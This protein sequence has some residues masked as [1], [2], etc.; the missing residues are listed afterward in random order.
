MLRSRLPGFTLVTLALVSL[1]FASGCGSSDKSTAP[2]D[3][4]AAEAAAQLGDQA[5]AAGDV[6]AANTHYKEALA[7]DPTNSHANLGAAVTEMGLLE[8]DAEVT[9]VADRLYPLLPRPARASLP[10]GIGRPRSALA[11][12][13]GLVGG[14]DYGPRATGLAM[15]NLL[16]RATEDPPL[17]SEVQSVLRT[18]VMPRLQYAEDRLGVLE[19]NANFSMLL[20][21][22][23]T[24]GPDT[25]EVDL[26]EVRVL[27]AVINELQGWLGMVVAYNFDFPMPS[28]LVPPDSILANGTSFGKLNTG[29][30]QLL[31]AARLDFLKAHTIFAA[32]AD[33]IA[34]ETDNQDDDLIP[35]AALQEQ[36][37][38]QF[39]SDFDDVNN[40]LQNTI[41]INVDDYQGGQVGIQLNIGSFFTNAIADW[42]TKLPA[43]TFD[44]T[45]GQPLITNPVTFP[46]PTFNG[47][48]PGMTNATWQSI[49]GPVDRPALATRAPIR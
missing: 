45:T 30:T 48:F 19:Q 14:R 34:A 40:A 42:K 21:P 18:R 23:L 16:M 29:G 46:D 13:T 17:L 20:D 28:E 36:G 33:G 22:E 12:F 2:P 24:G 10:L 47:I 35:Q 15:G 26:G 49:I 7:K 5:F 25:V 32:G 39:M 37:F 43:H 4:A 6:V 9:G 31:A 1:V 38:I 44:G 41:A 11:R 27:D 8:S 3:P